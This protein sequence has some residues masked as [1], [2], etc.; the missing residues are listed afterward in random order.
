MRKL[1]ERI[2]LNE[3]DKV[4]SA[5]IVDFDLARNLIEAGADVNASTAPDNN[6]MYHL[7]EGGMYDVTYRYGGCGYF[8]GEFHIRDKCERLDCEDCDDPDKRISNY[9]KNIVGLVKMLLDYGFDVTAYD[10]RTGA[11]LLT[12]L[13]YTCLGKYTIDIARCLLESGAGNYIYEDETVLDRLYDIAGGRYHEGEYGD[14]DRIMYICKM[15][16]EYESS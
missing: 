10:N 11:A 15:I 4:V 9:A 5:P 16:E 1:P 2:Y 13:P 3:L 8:K 14:Y 12:M 6:I 7:I